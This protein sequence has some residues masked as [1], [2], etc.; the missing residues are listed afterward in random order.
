MTIEVQRHQTL[1]DLAIQYCGTVEAV[2][3]LAALNGLAATDD[4]TPGTFIE[5]PDVYD[6]RVAK[7]FRDNDL[8][9]VTVVSP[10]LGSEGIEFWG[11][12]YDFIVS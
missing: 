5:I 7:Y 4:L 2:V 1:I 10:D 6:E 11:I 12:E 8:K 3:K 9:P